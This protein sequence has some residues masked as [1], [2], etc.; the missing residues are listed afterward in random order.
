MVKEA[1]KCWNCGMVLQMRNSPESWFW[2]FLRPE[3]IANL[4]Y[5][6]TTPMGEAEIKRAFS[7]AVDEGHIF[8][9][10]RCNGGVRPDNRHEYI[11][12][13]IDW[14]NWEGSA[15]TALERFKVMWEKIPSRVKLIQL[16]PKADY[17]QLWADRY[18]IIDE[19]LGLIDIDN[20][21][22]GGY[23]Q[24]IRF[25]VNDFIMM[26]PTIDDTDLKEEDKYYIES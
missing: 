8:L 17:V 1:D 23:N 4:L 24:T 16:N 6:E 20:D 18:D 11:Q 3:H 25:N 2:D 26:A 14:G 22:S 5:N 19:E 15:L 10:G 12:E 7:D 13:M 21:S 9:C